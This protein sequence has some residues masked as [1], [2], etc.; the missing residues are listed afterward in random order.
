MH[1][2]PCGKSA[3]TYG[4]PGRSC[5]GG[6]SN[7]L[8]IILHVL[9]SVKREKR[10]SA[11][12]SPIVCRRSGQK[13]KPIPPHVRPENR[14]QQGRHNRNLCVRSLCACNLSG[15]QAARANRHGLRSTVYDRLYLTDVGL[16]CTIGLPVGMGH[17]LPVHN[18]LPADTALCHT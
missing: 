8:Y 4:C 9:P 2:F 18:T 16:P 7:T 5:C 6:H 17:I 11:H 3:R 1:L 13:K 12:A 10:N 14:F 15:T